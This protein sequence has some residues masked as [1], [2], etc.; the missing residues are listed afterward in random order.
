MLS[1]TGVFKGTI[2]VGKCWQRFFYCR[3]SS[4]VS[5]LALFTKIV[6]N[7]WVKDPIISI[8]SVVTTILNTR[9]KWPTNLSDVRFNQPTFWVWAHFITTSPARLNLF[10]FFIIEAVLK[11][12][13]FAS[14]EAVP[15]KVSAKNNGCSE[16][17]EWKNSSDG[18]LLLF[19]LVV[20]LFWKKASTKNSVDGVLL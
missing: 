8:Y 5:G 13:Y 20:R 15:K 9:W 19:L 4:L 1:N 3:M 17:R 7:R 16:K 11:K 6:F 18:E 10:R 14:S 2:L 12:H